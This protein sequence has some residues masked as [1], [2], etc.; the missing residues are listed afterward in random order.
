MTED[1]APYG[2]RAPDNYK[3]KELLQML[4]GR[5]V[6]RVP[7]GW[8]SAEQIRASMGVSL[9]YIHKLV[10]DLRAKGL[11]L[12]VKKF[13]VACDTRGPYPIQHYKLSRQ[14]A[15]SIGLTPPD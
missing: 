6:D 1:P 10:R 14:L 15:E 13:K 4:A 12:D 3:T 8:Y 2:G 7:A 5:G 11:I 9:G